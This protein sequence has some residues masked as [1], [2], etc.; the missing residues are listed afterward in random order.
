MI[1]HRNECEQRLRQRVLKSTSEQAHPWRER[2]ISGPPF[3]IAGWKMVAIGSNTKLAPVPADR[4]A[5]YYELPEPNGPYD[6]YGGEVHDQQDLSSREVRCSGL[7]PNDQDRAG[8]LCNT[9]VLL[10][11][12][13]P[14]RRREINDETQAQEEGRMR[15]LGDIRPGFT[16]HRIQIPTKRCTTSQGQRYGR[17][18]ASSRLLRHV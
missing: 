14:G 3:S 15:Q 6:G 4:Q 5:G 12:M 8:C 16:G 9:C 1:N 18:R 7:L 11:H 13:R 10:E 17:V 2:I